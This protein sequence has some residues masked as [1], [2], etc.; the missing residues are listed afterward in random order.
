M[1][2]IKN[3]STRNQRIAMYKVMVVCAAVVQLSFIANLGGEG[4]I[5]NNDGDSALSIMPQKKR[6]KAAMCSIVK[7]EEAYIDEWVDYHHALGFDLFYIYDNSDGFEMKQ[8]GNEKGDYVRVI[9]FPGDA[10]QM[11]AYKDCG[12]RLKEG[13]NGHHTWAA[14][15][16]VDEFLV[17]KKHEHVSDFLEDHCVNGAIAVNWFFFGE[18]SRI[19]Y[20]P[21]PVTKRFIYR[22]PSVNQHVKSIVRLTDFNTEKDIKDPHHMPLKSGSQHDSNGRNFTGPFNPNGPTDVVVLHH[23]HTKSYKEYVHKRLRGRASKSWEKGNMDASLERANVAFERAL[24]GEKNDQDYTFFDE[25]AWTLMKKNVPYMTLFDE[26]D[27][28]NK[29]QQGTSN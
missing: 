22:V 8:W 27:T 16:D 12:K 15:F 6:K 24:A 26:I 14:F 17:I 25:T 13:G 20:T 7:N 10:K 9:H 3:I 4:E 2:H 11:L 19:V 5:V 1:V 28:T 21:L 29:S 23:F 18:S